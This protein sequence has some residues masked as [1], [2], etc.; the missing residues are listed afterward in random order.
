MSVV[1]V[2]LGH[3]CTPC[4]TQLCGE[5]IFLSCF[6]PSILYGVHISGVCTMIDHLSCSLFTVLNHL[7]IQ[8]THLSFWRGCIGYIVVMC[9]YIVVSSVLLGLVRQC[10]QGMT[11]PHSGNGPWEFPFLAKKS[12]IPIWP[13]FIGGKEAPGPCSF[14]PS[15]LATL[16]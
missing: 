15:S 5:A 16:Y 2:S 14:L 7:D 9:M 6:K 12:Y 4:C 1:D 11:R 8:R 3:I 13:T 10:P